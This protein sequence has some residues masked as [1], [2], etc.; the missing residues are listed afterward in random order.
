MGQL[1]FGAGGRGLEGL[2]ELGHPAG[3]AQ[4]GGQR[5]YVI[6][7]VGGP[8]GVGQVEVAQPQAQA[9]EHLRAGQQEG[10]PAVAADPQQPAQVEPRFPGERVDLDD[11]GD[12]LRLRRRGDG[13]RAAGERVPDDDRGPAQV[14]D[15]GEQVAGDVGAGE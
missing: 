8:G 3:F 7:V 10:A 6:G 4:L 11:P 1:C 14:I 9:A 2:L 15:Q 5:G 12:L 13:R